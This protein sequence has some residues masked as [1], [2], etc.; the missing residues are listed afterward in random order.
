M[1]KHKKEIFAVLC[2]LHKV[3]NN[4]DGPEG[5]NADWLL[6]ALQIWYFPSDSRAQV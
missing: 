3:K 6:K 2:L 4:W 1:E 5:S